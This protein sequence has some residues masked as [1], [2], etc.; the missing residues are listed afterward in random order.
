MGSHQCL[1][2]GVE[3]SKGRLLCICPTPLQLQQTTSPEFS[4]TPFLVP[5]GDEREGLGTLSAGARESSTTPTTSAHGAKEASSCTMAALAR[6]A[7]IVRGPG[8]ISYITALAA[9]LVVS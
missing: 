6:H 2:H 9:F 5:D 1:E 4:L 3:I 8:S 7:A